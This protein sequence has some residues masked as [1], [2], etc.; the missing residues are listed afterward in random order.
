M[1]LL[2][3]EAGVESEGERETETA[4]AIQRRRELRS[5][6]DVLAVLLTDVVGRVVG[7]VRGWLFVLLFPLLGELSR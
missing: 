1:D 3:Y 6:D 2:P 5:R 4:S 7:R